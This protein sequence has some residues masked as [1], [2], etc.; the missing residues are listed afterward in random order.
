MG[1]LPGGKL[2]GA[3][4]TW[5]EDW[6]FTESI[7][8]VLLETN[9]HDPYSVTVWGVTYDQKF[10]VAAV[11]SDSTWVQNIQQDPNV[12]LSVSGRLFTARA[13]M[14]SNTETLAALGQA[15]MAKY[16]VEPDEN[17]ARDGGVLFSLEER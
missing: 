3:V 2:E 14:V 11:D 5:P 17:F 4:E 13:V 6:S 15:Y 1:P 9:P 7:E 12:V 8:N 10:F 16:D